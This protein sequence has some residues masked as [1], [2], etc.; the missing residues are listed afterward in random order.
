MTRVFVVE[1]DEG[2][3]EVVKTILEREGHTVPVWIWTRDLDKALEAVDQAKTAGVSSAVVG[4]TFGQDIDGGSSIAQKLREAI[5]DIN[6]IAFS[7]ADWDLPWA[8]ISVQ[9]SD[10]GG[11]KKAVNKDLEHGESYQP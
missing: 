1:S 4:R 10:F 9:R 11:L 5:P 3:V 6:I 2:I 8:D 7:D